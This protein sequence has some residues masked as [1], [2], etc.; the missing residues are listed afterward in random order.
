MKKRLLVLAIVSLS[1]CNFASTEVKASSGEQGYESVELNEFEKVCL[2][3]S[4]VVRTLDSH[5]DCMSVL[6]YTKF[7]EY[8][9]Q[10]EKARREVKYAVSDYPS[11]IA[12]K[13]YM[14]ATIDIYSE[15][16]EY[17]E[18]EFAKYL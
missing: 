7:V 16:V 14:N 8:V 11:N 10:I 17:L 15:A 9:K 18:V 13:V 3:Y 2:R 1:L 6:E 5:K 4:K 12:N